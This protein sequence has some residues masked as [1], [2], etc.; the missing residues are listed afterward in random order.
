MKVDSKELNK[1]FKVL[2]DQEK[3]KKRVFVSEIETGAIVDKLEHLQFVLRIA[4]FE[5]KLKNE[6]PKQ[7]TILNQSI[8]VRYTYYSKALQH[9]RSYNIVKGAMDNES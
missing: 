6:N 7:R 3:A 5:F 8:S 4:N 2:S 1:W 9:I